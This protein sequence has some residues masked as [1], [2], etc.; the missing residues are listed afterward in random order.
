MEQ[1]KMSLFGG[2]KKSTIHTSELQQPST[3]TTTTAS[4]GRVFF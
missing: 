1:Q 4:R 3:T 2:N